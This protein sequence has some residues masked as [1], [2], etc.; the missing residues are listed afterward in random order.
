MESY[1][2]T[3]LMAAIDGFDMQQF[4]DQLA[5]RRDEV[6]GEVFDILLGLSDFEE[7]KGMMIAYKRG[8]GVNIQ[9]DINFSNHET[10]ERKSHK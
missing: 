2:K 7:F 6:T 1:I 8:R 5:E 3:E 9:L 4:M 10:C